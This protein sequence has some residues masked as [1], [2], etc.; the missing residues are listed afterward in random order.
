[1]NKDIATFLKDEKFLT[2]SFP[3]I[4]AAVN[5]K[6]GTKHSAEAIR[7]RWRRMGLPVKDGTFKAKVM[8]VEEQVQYD[9]EKSDYKDAKK[10]IETKYHAV[11]E[12]ALAAEKERDAF[13]I[14]KESPRN[15]FTVHPKYNNKK[16]EATAVVIA[17]D[18]HIE[19]KVRPESVN[20]KNAHNLTVAEA[21]AIEFFAN[22]I[23]LVK[24]EQQDVQIDTLVLALLGDFISGNI[25]EELLENCELTPI[26]AIIK[27]K[28]LITAGIEALLKETNLKLV[29]PCHVG[30]HTRITKK[31]HLSNEQGNSLEYFM[32]HTLADY[33]QGNKRVEFIIAE[34]YHSY[35]TIY[36]YTIRFHHG[37]SIKFGGG[38]GGIMIPVQK[39]ISQWNKIRWADLDCFGHLH[40]QM[41]GKNFLANG[42]NIGYNSF[43]VAIKADFD[44]P[45]Q[46]FFLI[47]KKRGKT[48]VAPIVYSI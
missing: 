23:K 48:V 20:G 35:V 4:T 24:K 19:E 41:D 8:T 11:L 5:K 13:K 17:S 29:I 12:R 10:V 6:F 36:N 37:H 1:M 16:G 47:D 28:N 21:R 32:Y 30:N 3:E 38:V 22:T 15:E 46:T 2:M 27:A 39:A 7:G 45:R 44:T 42:S 43:A 34:G 33:F 31:I 18:W 40:V 9:I 14:L 25:H 26:A